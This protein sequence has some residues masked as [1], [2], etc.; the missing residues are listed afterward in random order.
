MTNYDK[1]AKHY[2]EVMGNRSSNATELQKI[3]SKHNPYARTILE[4]ACGTGS[5]L[6]HFAGQY[7]VYGLDLS[8]GMLSIARKKVPS[9]IFS[10]QDM[11]EFQFD[12]KFDV[13]LCVFDSINHLLT[14][15]DWKKVFKRVYMHLNEGGVFIFDMNTQVKLQ[16]VTKERPWVLSFGKHLMIMDVTDAGRA[17]SNWNVKIFEHKKGGQYVLYEEDIKEKSF[18]LSQVKEALGKFQK[19]EV[20]DAESHKRP[21]AK[22][23]RV[24]FICEK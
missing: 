15:S 17:V 8:K 13:I 22:S 19:V 6:Q 7:E 10:Q 21:S 9:G 4:L 14:F 12:Q 5:I 1:F 11:T 2:D 18:P 23:E 16:R 24:V 20:I 3:I